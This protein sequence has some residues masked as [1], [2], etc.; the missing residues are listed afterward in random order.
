VTESVVDGAFLGL[1]LMLIEIRLELLSGFIEVREK[2]L[3][4]AER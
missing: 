3:A 2:F 1:A 4:C